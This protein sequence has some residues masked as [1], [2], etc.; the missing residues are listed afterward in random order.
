MGEGC[1]VSLVS[2]HLLSH[3]KVLNSPSDAYVSFLF[4]GL[5][6]FVSLRGSWEFRL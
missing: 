2:L 6:A 1:L 4:L 5:L 3:V